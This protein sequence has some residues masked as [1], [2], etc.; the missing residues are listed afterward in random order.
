MIVKGRRELRKKRKRNRI[1]DGERPPVPN[2]QIRSIS[3]NSVLID[4][5]AY[6]EVKGKG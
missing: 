3:D 6:K 1:G 2:A 4:N 5:F